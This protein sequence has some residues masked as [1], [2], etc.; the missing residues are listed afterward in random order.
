MKF[1]TLPALALAFALFFS[2]RLF[3][4]Y[5]EAFSTRFDLERGASHVQGIC[6]TREAIYFS[7]DKFLYKCDWDGNLVKKIPAVNHSG[8]V[9]WHRGELYVSICLMRPL[10][11]GERGYIIVY[12]ADLNEIRRSKPFPRPADGIFGIGDVLYVG[13]GSNAKDPPKPHRNNWFAKFDIRTLEMIGDKISV[14]Y[15]FDTCYGVQDITSDG[16]R[17]FLMFY[18][19][20]GISAAVTDLD[21]KLIRTVKGFT[22]SNG[23]DPIE[24]PAPDGSRRFLRATTVVQNRSGGFNDRRMRIDFD[25]VTSAVFDAR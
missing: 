4:G 12:D 23:L 14:D 6:T 9:C 25:V 1:N 2:S 5:G 8:D 20:Q 13:L 3:A 11:G 7:Q 21:Y 15:G 16:K 22:A 19:P 10:P 17:L 18:G 24:G